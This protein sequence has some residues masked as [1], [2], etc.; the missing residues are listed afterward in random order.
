M[1]IRFPFT[2]GGEFFVDAAT[3]VRYPRSEQLIEIQLFKRGWVR[4][5]ARRRTEEA[6]RPVLFRVFGVTRALLANPR[7]E[8]AVRLPKLGSTL[9]LVEESTYETEGG[10]KWH[11]NTCL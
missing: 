8:S 3:V 2:Q 11:M 6:T 9:R 5:R 10:Q 1:Q 4:L 7:Q